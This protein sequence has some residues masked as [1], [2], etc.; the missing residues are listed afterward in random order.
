MN[1][2]EKVASAADV[3]QDPYDNSDGNGSKHIEKVDSNYSEYDDSIENT[4]PSRAVW[5]ITFTVAMG[6]FLFG[7]PR[8]WQILWSGLANEKFA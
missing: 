8:A 3:P 4:P 5:L 6:G 1:A 7:K 2:S